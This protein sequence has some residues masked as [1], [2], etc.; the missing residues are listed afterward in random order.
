MQSLQ[1]ALQPFRVNEHK[2]RADHDDREKDQ[3]DRQRDSHVQENTENQNPFA[4]RL[5]PN[6][7]WEID[8][9]KQSRERHEGNRERYMLQPRVIKHRELFIANHGPHSCSIPP[10]WALHFLET[11]KTV[12]EAKLNL[13]KA[14]TDGRKPVVD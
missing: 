2:I 12:D 10:T 13:H 7:H 5:Q 3:S 9:E 8:L 1:R 4:N 11:R 6:E 14:R